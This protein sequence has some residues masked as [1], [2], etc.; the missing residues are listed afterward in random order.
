MPLLELKEQY[1][2]T[3]PIGPIIIPP[4]IIERARYIRRRNIDPRV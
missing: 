1:K 4:Y 3:D 2:D